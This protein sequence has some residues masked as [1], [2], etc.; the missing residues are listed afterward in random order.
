VL[1]GAA[2]AEFSR[3]NIHLFPFRAAFTPGRN[4]PKKPSLALANQFT[5]F[6]FEV[7]KLNHKSD[8]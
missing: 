4:T 2:A 5:V 7:E 6:Y 8:K 1:A 3:K